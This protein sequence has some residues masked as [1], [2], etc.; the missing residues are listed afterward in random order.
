M[1]RL[2][3]K[4]WITNIDYDLKDAK[5][6]TYNNGNS[7]MVTHLSTNPSVLWLT[8]AEQ[9]GSGGFKVRWS[10]VK[11]IPLCLEYEPRRSGDGVKKHCCEF[12]FY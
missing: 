6:K 2:H 7:P 4:D 3:G 9:T 8:G 10:Y 5:T 1:M 12:C 11:E